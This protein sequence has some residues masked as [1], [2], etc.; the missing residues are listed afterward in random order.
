MCVCVC[1][2]VWCVEGRGCVRVVLRASVLVAQ[3]GA[4]KDSSEAQ[5][6]LATAWRARL[7]RTHPL[8][9]CGRARHAHPPEQVQRVGDVVGAD[10]RHQHKRLDL[11]GL[12]CSN[13]VQVAVVVH[14]E[15]P[16]RVGLVVGPARHDDGGAA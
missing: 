5:P 12:R 4:R 10:A 11:G 16:E 3:G 9:R 13:E 6:T 1:V 15:G 7:D 14:V 2:C 8:T